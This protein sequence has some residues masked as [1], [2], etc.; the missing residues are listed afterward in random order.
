MTTRPWIGAAIKKPSSLLPR[1]SLRLS[2]VMTWA[3]ADAPR[4]LRLLHRTSPPPEWLVLVP[5]HLMGSDLEEIITGNTESS[6]VFRYET[7]TNDIV[8]M[9]TSRTNEA[10]CV[11][12]A[13]LTFSRSA[14]S[15]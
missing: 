11:E 4:A 8:Y 12:S 9:G 15:R 13:P 6:H 10:S 14:G 2:R 5:Q 1:R 3:F 7:V